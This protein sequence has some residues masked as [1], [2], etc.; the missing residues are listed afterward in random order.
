VKKRDESVFQKTA[1]KLPTW[2]KI[3][4]S[5]VFCTLFFVLLEG[6]LWV[7]GVQPVLYKSD[8]YVGFSSLVPLFVSESRPGGPPVMV[9]AGNKEK[10]FNAQEFAQDKPR[11]TTRIFC[12]GGS[13]TYGRPFDDTTSFSGWLRELLPVAAPD[14]DWDVINAGGISYASYRVALLMEELVAYEPDLFIIYSG[15]N[16]FLERRTYA[17]IIEMPAPMRGTAAWASR[18]RTFSLIQS[19]TRAGQS[20]T[21]G[22][23]TSRQA[24]PREVKALLDS[25]V[26]P[27]AYERNDMLR[28]Q[29]L[30]H[31]RYNLARMVDIAGSVGAR[32]VFI[33]PASNLRDCSPFKSEHSPDFGP[34]QSERWRVL[35]ARAKEA[36][37]AG[38]WER[39]LAPLEEACRLDPRY[40]NVHYLNGRVLE[41]L[42][43]CGEA[44]DAYQRA[45][46][47]DICPLR[48]LTGMSQTVRDI[49]AEWGADVVDFEKAVTERARD[50]IPGQ[51]QFLDHVHP[52]ID[53]HRELALAIID[54]LAHVDAISP[55]A[56]WTDSNSRAKAI[57]SAALR[58][59]SRVDRSAQGRAM[60]NVSKVFGWAGKLEDALVAAQRAVALSPEMPE[61]HFYLA[62]SG[63][64]LD[65]LDMAVK[66]YGLALRAIDASGQELDIHADAL[67]NMGIIHANRGDL[68]TAAAYYE[69]AVQVDGESV[70]AH[71]NLG[72]VRMEQQKL[73]EAE[74][75]FQEALRLDID[76]ASAHFNLGFVLSARGEL[77]RA[78]AHFV[79][80]AQLLPGDAGT[81]F[82]LGQAYRE[83]QLDAE[84]VACF[85][86]ALA[87][88]G[89][90]LGAARSL[91]WLLAS[92]SE[93]AVR[94]GTEAV[95]RARVCVRISGGQEGEDY[96]VLAAAYAEAG[97]YDQ[98]VIAARQAG[99]L[100]RRQGKSALAAAIEDRRDLYAEGKPY[101]NR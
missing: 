37:E 50:N 55:V 92:S 17:N 18:L 86:R 78:T 25:S 89:Q 88:D 61:A 33:T 40:A 71:H 65:R 96:D 62:S 91:A 101:R 44:R 24:L 22:S 46:D 83:Q 75:H 54:C 5:L 97:Q 49:A 34:D 26:G 20:S 15:H 4:F 58:I 41:R 64:K 32:V 98:A 66:H 28:E 87:V 60:V 35:L 99:E 90:H 72:V 7:C 85:R 70:E 59:E 67:N 82:A 80:A 39:A 23:A 42:G 9:R 73:D 36:Y 68:E 11:G 2:K 63:H 48:A 8:P 76:D 84:A 12:V 52:S 21:G 3:L 69:R 27:S 6:V 100:A 45:R 38:R 94:D 53:E 47:E 29:V 51:A 79:R 57:E 81:H 14:R 95:R 31:Y 43:R 16:E 77:P 30:S 1:R 74:S 93:Q 13:T 19:F 56:G 10:F